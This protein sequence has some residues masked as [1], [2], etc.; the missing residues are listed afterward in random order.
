[1]KTFKE[2]IEES[3]KRKGRKYDSRNN[4]DADSKHDDVKI[5]KD[6]EVVTDIH[7]KK[8][9]ITYS[10]IHTDGVD[11]KNK[12]DSKMHD[13]K[14]NHSVSWW[15]DHGDKIDDKKK[16]QIAK[17]AKHVYDKHVHHRIPSGHLVSNNP[18]PNY[19]IQKGKIKETNTRAKIYQ[20][21]GFGKLGKDR[22]TQYSVKIGNKLHPVDNT[23]K[24]KGGEGLNKEK[25][26]A[27]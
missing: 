26:K 4:F 21:S 15:H 19:R 1:M 17:D 27:K 20:R 6:S 22:K 3:T 10:V 13:K 9:G 8:S 11:K 12:P 2:F 24:R 7:H 18:Q 14:P 25:K 23:G 16:R 5:N